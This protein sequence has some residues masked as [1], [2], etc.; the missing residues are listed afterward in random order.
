MQKKSKIIGLPKATQNA[1]VKN[2]LG[3]HPR[4]F[5]DDFVEVIIE[6]KRKKFIKEKKN[7]IQKK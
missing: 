4:K 3:Q 1:Y 5:S 6:E 7:V 2:L